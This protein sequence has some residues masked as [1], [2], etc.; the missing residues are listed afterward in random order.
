[1]PWPAIAPLISAM[2][3]SPVGSTLFTGFALAYIYLCRLAGSCR[4]P[5]CGSRL[6]NVPVF[7][8]MYRARN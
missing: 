8:S 7:G 3:V 6:R 2:D 1:M 4:F 5:W